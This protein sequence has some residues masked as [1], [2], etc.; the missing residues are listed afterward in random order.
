MN[1]NDVRFFLAVSRHGGL[2]GAARQLK[3]SASTVARRIE[4]LEEDL[5]T[6]LF[7]RSAD[8]YELT[9][10]GQSMV[11][12]AMAIEASMIELADDFGNEDGRITGNVRLI[13]IE[14]LAQHLVIPKLSSLQDRHPDLSLGVAVNASFARLP[15]READVGL[16]LCRPE[17]GSFTIKRIGALAL[18]LYAS[19]DFLA[20]HPADK[21]AVPIDGRDVIAWSDP[22]SFT[23]VPKARRLW[24]DEADAALTVDSMAANLLAVKSGRGFGVLPCI[25]GDADH[26]IERVRPDLF[27]RE[28][29]IW[30]VVHEDIR[31]TRRVREVCDFL[32][33]IVREKDTALRG[34][35]PMR[36]AIRS[37]A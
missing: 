20:R 13:T 14:T 3:V 36:V 16:R 9:A 29:D 37:P 1:W 21:L 12:K 26:A 18:G 11:A 22:L 35:D 27:N 7:D 28:E 19:H 6:R 33:T 24:A 17:S 2:T 30:L 25:M 34:I 31:H 15:Q 23:A 5:G 10:R 4:S 32:E 8:G